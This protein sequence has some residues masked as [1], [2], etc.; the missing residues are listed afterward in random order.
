[1]YATG[2]GV[3]QDYEEAARWFRKSAEQGYDKAL[4]NLGILYSKGTGVPQDFLQA[5]L[6]FQLAA[7]QGIQDAMVY[8][9]VM[10]RRMTP[11][12]SPRQRKWQRR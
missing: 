12:R 6:C 2:K 5:Y 3:P 10:A 9:D 4:Y 7:D 1:M 8:L 11:T